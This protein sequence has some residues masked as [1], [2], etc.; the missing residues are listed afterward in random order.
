MGSKTFV[1][2]NSS[3][4]ASEIINKRGNITNE[5]P[6]MP[7]AHGLIGQGKQNVLHPIAQWSEPRRILNQMLNGTSLRLYEQWQDVESLSLLTA[8]VHLPHRWYSHHYRYFASLMHR[9]TLDGPLQ[10]STSE[11][12]DMQ[13]ASTEFLLSIN[14]SFI[15]F[16]P[17]LAGLPTFLQPWRRQKARIGIKHYNLFRQWWNP[18]K[19][20]ILKSTRLPSFFRDVLQQNDEKR[21]EVEEGAMYLSLSTI[22]AGSDSPSIVLNGLVMAALCHPEV[23]LKA[24][25]E[26][27]RVCG[28]NA[29][30]LP[31][32]QDIHS[33]PYVCALVKEILR[34]RPTVPV[35][36]QHQLTQDLEFE[37]YSFPAGTEF[38]VNAASICSKLADGREELVPERWLNED[39]GDINHGIW[40]FGGGRRVCAGRDLT[41]SS[42][43][44]ASA[45]L[46]Y[47][48][49]YSAVSIGALIDRSIGH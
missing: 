8:Y 23:L 24:R 1:F 13:H 10:K 41:Q 40:Q 16:F 29:E 48:F 11:L 17:Q 28:S 46:L 22:A 26:A 27:D 18:A 5:R 15:D 34:W 32:S 21:I 47:C 14:E 19:D 43:F 49:D 12:D 38:L 37:G 3:R 39:H 45:R 7:I 6:P 36:I 25:T 20:A 30:R 33:M 35:V 9:I 31:G 42:L 2:L 44:L 4:A